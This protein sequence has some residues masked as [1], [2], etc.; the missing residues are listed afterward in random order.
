MTES[1]NGNPAT[2]N[3]GQSNQEI[4]M[5]DQT[6]KKQRNMSSSMKQKSY[7]QRF[8]PKIITFVVL[9]VVVS[10]LVAI[11]AS[12]KPFGAIDTEDNSSLVVS[13][14]SITQQDSYRIRREYVGIVEARRESRVGFEL[15]GKIT[16][17]LVDEGDVI[18]SGEV[19]GRLDTAL[20]DADRV[21][22]IA[23]H[24]QARAMLELADLTRD[25]MHEAVELNA[26]SI[27]Q[28]DEAD[29]SHQA[30][31]ALLSKVESA[32]A[33]IDVRLS[34]SVLIAP[35]DA[36][37][38]KRFIDEGQVLD[39]GS[40]VYFLL[41]RVEPEVRI[42]VAGQS[43]DALASGQSFELK[44]RDRLIPA[45][46]KT[47]LPVRGKGTRSVD[48][49]FTLHTEFDGIRRGDLATLTVDATK[50]ETGFWLPLTAL[51]ESSRGLWA[52]FVAVQVDNNARVGAG[53]HRLRRRELEI[54]HQNAA[55]VYVRG[56]LSD[57]E[58]VIVEGLH[59]LVQ[60]LPVRL[61]TNEA[62]R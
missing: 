54:I 34:K 40:F 3:A 53:T 27:Q 19:L 50:F 8:A 14:V 9:S 46:I 44:V 1:R 58:L 26:I 35:F 38:A 15:S 42:G 55:G 12:T 36:I 60:D 31:A 51:T 10:G 48:V 22:L 2:V 28:W 24:D 33:A 20:L 49:V 47:I 59:R 23:D 45:T 56:T 5:K 17:L 13:A 16:E 62:K 43:I 39:A 52:C 11:G 57:G 37:V 32:I 4:P 6:T 25:R 61:A 30:Q 7:L 18:Q 29:K 21:T 41:E